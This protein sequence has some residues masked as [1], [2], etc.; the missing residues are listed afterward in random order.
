[1]RTLLFL[2]AA[3]A[4]I[5]PPISYTPGKYFHY[6]NLDYLNYQ[7]QGHGPVTLVLLHGFGSSLYNWDDIRSQFDTNRYTV[8]LFDLKGFGFSSVP[9]NTSYSIKANAYLISS[10]IRSQQ[11]SNF[12]LIG[13]SL[14]G[15]VSL[16]T[17]VL[18]RDDG[19]ELPKG[20]ILISSA[21]YPTELPFFIKYLRFPIVSRTAFS[22]TSPEFKARYSLERMYNNPEIITD[23]LLWRYA[24]FMSSQKFPAFAGTARDIVPG[25]IDELTQSYSDIMCP[26]LVIWGDNDPI[27]PLE[28]GVRLAAEIPLANLEILPDCGHIPQEEYPKETAKLILDFLAIHK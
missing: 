20:M 24:A 8:Y 13:H 18:L 9:S 26:V 6:S 27:L 15:G 7:V 19:G 23:T 16:Y 1:M 28:S 11:L 12:W 2:L 14:G 3:C 22:A 10:F 5:E 25:N 21:A 17:H 4:H